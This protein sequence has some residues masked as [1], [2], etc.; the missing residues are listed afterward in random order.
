[1]KSGHLFSSSVI[2]TSKLLNLDSLAQGVAKAE[3][4]P[5]LKAAKMEVYTMW[6]GA[7]NLNS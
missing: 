7:Q 6:D 2:D 3:I 5:G 1:M 4:L